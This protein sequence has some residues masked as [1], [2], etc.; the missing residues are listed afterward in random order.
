MRTAIYARVS[1]ADQDCAL[2]L[3]DLRQYVK[4]RG[5]KIAG[6]FIDRGWS[7]AKASRPEL[8]RLMAECR[9]RRVDCIIVWKLDRWGRS[10]S[11]LVATLDELRNLGVRWIATTQGLD[12]DES[13]PVG[14][15]LLQL[16]AAIAEF[17]RA[18]IQ[19]RVKAG[20]K[21]AQARGIHCGRPRKVVDRLKVAE[22]RAGGMSFR[23]IAGSLG[24]SLAKV[25]R[26]VSLLPPS[27]GQSA[28]SKVR[29]KRRP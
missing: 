23:A 1:T 16:L 17:E 20:V 9:A 14:R 10:V 25:Q 29:P 4:A 28:V 11:N 2:Q 22:M 21:A 8:D 3:R 7:G 18:L 27:N 19:E 5:W 12:T 13:S 15:L 6:E 24:I 26:T